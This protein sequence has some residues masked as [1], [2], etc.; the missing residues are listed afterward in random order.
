MNR[1]SITFRQLLILLG[2][3]MLAPHP[4]AIAQEGQSSPAADSLKTARISAFAGYV[5]EYFS[6]DYAVTN[7]GG[8]TSA[9][10][11]GAY[12]RGRGRALEIGVGYARELGSRV[13]LRGL[14]T[15]RQ[16]SHQQSFNC[17]DPAQIL[18]PTG[19]TQATTRF[20]NS[21]DLSTISFSLLADYQPFPF[22]L[23]IGI[24]PT[25]GLTI[26]Q[27]Y[28]AQEEVVTPA[29]AEFVEGG[30]QRTIGAG[31]GEGNHI[32]IAADA[33]VAY[34]IIAGRALRILPS[35]A[36]RH[37]V[38]SPIAW[39]PFDWSSISLRLGLEYQLWAAPAPVPSIAAA[40][41]TVAQPPQ[42]TAESATV[43]ARLTIGWSNGV[44]DTAVIQQQKLIRQQSLPILPFIFFDSGSVAIPERYRLRLQPDAEASEAGGAIAAAIRLHRRVLDTIGWRMQAAPSARITIAGTAPDVPAS[45][46]IAVATARA[47]AVQNYLAEVWKI[48]RQRMA[49]T[50]TTMPESPTISSS[51]QGFAENIRA[52]I[53]ADTPAILAPIIF[54]DTTVSVAAA[55]IAG[56]V[57]P[58]SDSLLAV[59]VARQTGA[60]IRL[61]MRTGAGE[62]I[63]V[64]GSVYPLPN[65]GANF[66]EHLE[67]AATT[68]NGRSGPP[69]VLYLRTV[70]R[71]KVALEA[72]AVFPFGSA[73]LA[74]KDAEAIRQLRRWSDSNATATLLG[75]T[76]D[77]GETAGNLQLSRNR[78]A[79]VAQLLGLANTTAEGIG[80]IANAATLRYPEERMYAR[81]T[82]ARIEE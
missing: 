27:E 45:Q 76:D 25:V 55:T 17:T 50:A 5:L 21:I 56:V 9:T 82:L 44:G 33:D 13:G 24:G 23:R 65:P 7:G 62:T 53:S 8:I 12:Q 6:S 20:V 73:Q 31:K 19:T 48:A 16:G 11:C 35:V 29:N 4:A 49:T 42:A 43:P 58:G 75:S 52:E 28:F 67:I 40:P 10:A 32:S 46:A 18:T 74:G 72:L 79:A 2:C 54:R 39:A 57:S 77:L 1:L 81:S 69:V 71:R 51:A 22:P 36:F 80:E 66:T 61:T 34:P 64:E 70:V 26:K 59:E 41:V 3:W 60:R 15:L 14:L 78:A 47:A 37:Y 68:G 63:A 30:Q 38:R